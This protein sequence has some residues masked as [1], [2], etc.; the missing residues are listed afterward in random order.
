MNTQ[1]VE[2]IGILRS[3]RKEYFL[4]GGPL[5]PDWE[6]VGERRFLV[7]PQDEDAEIAGRRF[8]YPCPRE[9]VVTDYLIE[10]SPVAAVL[11]ERP[12]E[13]P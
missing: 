10:Y 4:L 3:H 1:V 6:G 11:C 8:I 9:I 5:S 12:V 2:P 7:V 13:E